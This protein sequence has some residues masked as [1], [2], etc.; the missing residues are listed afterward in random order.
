MLRKLLLSCWLACLSM[1]LYAHEEHTHGKTAPAPAPTLAVSAAFDH[2]GRLWR[3][4][5][6]A[7]RVMVDHS[8]DRGRTFS[9]PVAVNPQ[10]EKIGAEGELRPKIALGKSGEIYVSWTQALAKPYAG[11]IRFSRSLDGGKSFSGP[12][13]V[14]RNRDPI[15]HRFDSLAVADDGTVYV[16]W[17][18]KRDLQA[19]QA[20]GKP[21]AGA[22][23][24]YAVSRDG[25]TRFDAEYKVADS[26]CECCRIG[27]A[28]EPGGTAVM[29]W[30][31]VYEGSIRDH[32]VARIGPSGVLKEPVRASYGN[33]KLDACPH[34]GGSIARGGDW[35][36][37]LAWYDGNEAKPGLYVARMDGE[38]WV[39]SPAR[40]F[41][42]A[43]AQA[44][45]PALV[46][47]GEQVFLA[48]KELTDTSAVIMAMVSDDGGRSWGEPRR[49]AE[50]AGAADNP[51]LVSD[52]KQ[53]YLSWNTRQD[54]YRLIDLTEPAK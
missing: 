9:T 46:A 39:A 13:V 27:L 2:Q 32:A 52:G 4:A 48:W 28:T 29:F 43:D 16:A 12:M 51:F 38:A 17:I 26:S 36:W 8:D 33:W 54:G 19:A 21:Y 5:V 3:A 35:G 24:Y 41:G 7:G 25:G 6:D 40:R 31:H 11:H 1:P 49:V 15:T 18:D 23:V 37:H 42:N 30:R 20:A 53:V 22:A 14:N 50:T 45:H 34:H 44:G 47:I 10:P